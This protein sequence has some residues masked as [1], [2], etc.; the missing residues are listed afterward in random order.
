MS[1][2]LTVPASALRNG[3]V[4]ARA[5][6]PVTPIVPPP[7]PPFL[8]A[9]QQADAQAKPI[10]RKILSLVGHVDLCSRTLIEG[11]I[12]WVHF[13]SVKVRMQVFV[14]DKLVGECVADRPRED[15]REAG[16]GDGTCAFSYH[17]PAEHPIEDVKSLRLRVLG[18]S[19][20]LLP[21]EFTRT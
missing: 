7:L 8:D 9:P 1:D 5:R 16:H 17:I 20:F 4:R 15:L 18:S 21:D 3:L 11:W 10:E 13:P 12:V 14:G 6:R 2:M 19:V